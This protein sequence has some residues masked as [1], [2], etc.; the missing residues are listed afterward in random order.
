VSKTQE[1]ACLIAARMLTAGWKDVGC[2]WRDVRVWRILRP[3]CQPSPDAKLA[4]SF[5][6]AI[7]QRTYHQWRMVTWR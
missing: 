1:Q 7:V 5:C 3:T 2:Q 4:C 6:G